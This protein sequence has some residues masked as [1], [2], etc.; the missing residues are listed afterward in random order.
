MS[1]ETDREARVERGIRF[2]LVIA[3]CAL[4]ISTLATSASWWQARVLQ[5]QTQV[6]EE[7]LGAQV[8]PYVSVSVGFTGRRVDISIS[9]DGL[10][11][12]VLRSVSAA[13]DNVPK[14]NFVDIMHAILGPN[15]VAR[16]HRQGDNITFAIDGGGP[17]SI[18]RPGTAGVSFAL[19]SKSFARPFVHAY[20]RLTFHICYCAIIPGKCWLG[21]SASMR[22]PMPVQ[23]CPEIANDLLHAPTF[24]ELLD[25]NF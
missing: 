8:W 12:A 2:D 21:D 25:R 19:T 20:R 1:K 24:E 10:G 3:V 15:L 4:L 23:S 6:L 9:N 18:V 5:A 7:Q 22:D 14:S 13:V 17:G 16:S 11:P